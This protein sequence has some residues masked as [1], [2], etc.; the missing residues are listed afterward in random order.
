M[1]RDP[2]S[3]P[4]PPTVPQNRMRS[5]PSR[6]HP[7]QTPPGRGGWAASGSL[8]WCQVGGTALDPPSSTARRGAEPE[9]PCQAPLGRGVASSSLPQ[10]SSMQPQVPADCSLRLVTG[11]RPLLWVQPSC[12]MKT[13][14]PLWA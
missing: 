1:P 12:V 4:C 3:S 6:P 10:P 9:V 14:P 11:T 5:R 2:E 7:G 13:P 8:A